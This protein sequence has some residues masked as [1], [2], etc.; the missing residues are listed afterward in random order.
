MEVLGIPKTDNKTVRFMSWDSL[1][2]GSSP[3]NTR[4]QNTVL[5]DIHPEDTEYQNIHELSA[6]DCGN[7]KMDFVDKYTATWRLKFIIYGPKSFEYAQK[8]K[9]GFFLPDIKYQLQELSL[10][11]V[12]TIP[13]VIHVPEK[14]DEEWWER[15]DLNL[16]MYQGVEN[17]IEN[18]INPIEEITFHAVSEIGEVEKTVETPKKTRK[19]KG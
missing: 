11:I 16:L 10:F 4:S 15:H 19:R 14:I 9:T 12:P 17:V 8:I 2:T 6:Q 18:A 7:N 13:S 1:K 5:I 3:A